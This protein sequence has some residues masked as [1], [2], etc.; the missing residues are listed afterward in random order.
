MKNNLLF[1]FI[2]DKENSKVTVK[3]EFKANLD[4]VWDMWTKPELLDQW[5]APEP[6]VSKTKS[7]DFKVGGIRLY[8]MCGPNGE[9]HWGLEKYT[10]ISPKT[11]YEHLNA[12]CDS[13][14]NMNPDFPRSLWK[15]NF[16]SQDDVTRVEISIHHKKWEDLQKYIEMGFKEGFTMT[17]D[18]LDTLLKTLKSK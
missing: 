7:M 16:S 12:F 14:G 1:D 15:L 6:Y 13:E 17:L 9:E 4:M 10:S 3:R 18:S 2:V 5:W 8:A 11:Y